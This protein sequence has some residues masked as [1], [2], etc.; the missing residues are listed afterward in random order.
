ML[1]LAALL[2]L[3]V[4]LLLLTIPAPTALRR[5]H[6][7]QARRG[8]GGG[9]EGGGGEGGGGE[10]SI[11]EQSAGHG[12]HCG[13]RRVD[14]WRVV[15]HKLPRADPPTLKELEGEMADGMGS[16][17]ALQVALVVP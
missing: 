13:D 5:L 1:L 9:G 8:G 11:V 16:L 6:A 2:A 10:G 15:E 7:M 4:L 14:K 3:V 17:Q 12:H